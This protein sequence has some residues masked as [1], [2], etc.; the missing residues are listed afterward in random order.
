MMK[1]TAQLYLESRQPQQRLV[2]W[3][4]VC[5]LRVMSLVFFV[6]AIAIWMRAIGYW[7]GPFNRFDTMPVWLRV[8]TAILAVLYPVVSMGLWST[9][10]WGRVVWYMAVTVAIAMPILFGGQGFAA[11]SGIIVFHISCIAFYLLLRLWLRSTDK[12]R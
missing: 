3:I 1:S 2:G 10:S 6:L 11:V 4:T 8:Q 12:E 9:L 5:F 7:D